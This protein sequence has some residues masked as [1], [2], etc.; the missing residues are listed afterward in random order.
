MCNYSDMMVAHVHHDE[1][2]ARL[3][4]TVFCLFMCRCCKAQLAK[5]YRNESLWHRSGYFWIF[6]EEAA[7]LKQWL[8]IYTHNWQNGQIFKEAGIV[9][10]KTMQVYLNHKEVNVYGILI[11]AC[12]V[13]LFCIVAQRLGVVHCPSSE[14]CLYYELQTWLGERT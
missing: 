3:I 7:S 2:E 14:Y 10:R 6:V 5:N 8:L 4:R 9:F 13:P 12:L 1:D 11:L